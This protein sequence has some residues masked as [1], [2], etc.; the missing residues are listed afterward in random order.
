MHC[1]G[2][3]EARDLIKVTTYINFY[4]NRCMF[5]ILWKILS[6]RTPFFSGDHTQICEPIFKIAKYIGLHCKMHPSRLPNVFI[7]M[8]KIIWIYMNL[9]CQPPFWADHTKDAITCF[10]YSSYSYFSWTELIWFLCQAYLSN[11]NNFPSFQ[12]FLQETEIKPF[13]RASNDL[14]RLN[15]DFVHPLASIF[16]WQS[17]TCANAQGAW[18]HCV[19]ISRY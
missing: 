5:D 2:G 17:S 10:P 19:D 3:R 9:I 13:L 8:F 14:K 1:L 6:V 4:C 15:L 16:F 11:S 18:V 7:K 12:S